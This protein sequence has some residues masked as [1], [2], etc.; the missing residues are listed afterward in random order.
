MGLGGLVLLL[1][2]LLLRCMDRGVD[3]CSG[4]DRDGLAHVGVRCTPTSLVL[5]GWLIIFFFNQEQE[6][7]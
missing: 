2:L 1:L 6:G 7:R 4:H 5:S 3:I